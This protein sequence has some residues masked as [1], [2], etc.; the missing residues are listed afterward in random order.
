[1]L[2]KQAEQR[3]AEAYLPLNPAAL[4]R[5]ID[6]KINSLLQAYETKNRTSGVDTHRKLDPRMVT[7]FMIQQATVGLP[8]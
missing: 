7:S 5:A 2:S 6:A 3:L 1:Q 8:S 4:K